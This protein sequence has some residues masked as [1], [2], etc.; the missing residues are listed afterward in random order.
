MLRSLVGS[1]MCIRDSTKPA[2]PVGSVRFVGLS[3]DAESNKKAYTNRKC[4]TNAG[5]RKLPKTA[6]HLLHIP[7]AHFHFPAAFHSFSRMCS[8]LWRSNTHVRHFSVERELVLVLR[9]QSQSRRLQ[10]VL[11]Q[12][13]VNVDNPVSGNDLYTQLHKLNTF[14]GFDAG[15]SGL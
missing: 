9:R 11:P 7:P 15:R 5:G 8:S 1:E 2:I 13:L 10:T 12:T 6:I 4:R 14:K 3:L